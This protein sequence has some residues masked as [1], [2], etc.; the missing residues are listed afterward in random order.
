MKAKTRSRVRQAVLAFPN[1]HGGARKGAG[2]KPT[3]ERAGVAHRTRPEL[4]ER[5]PVH[6]TLRLR[7]GL[8][9][10][11]RR[12]TLA[13][14][15]RC[16]AA[17]GDKP[18]FRLCEFSIQS[19]HLHLIV[20]ASG[21]SALSRGMQGLA[22]RIARALNSAWRRKGTVF[23]DRYHARILE[24]PTEVRN[25]LRYVLHNARHHGTRYRGLDRFSSGPWFTGWLDQTPL[26]SPSP[27]ARA[28]TWLLRTG[29]WQRMRGLSIHC[30]PA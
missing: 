5:F 11:R 6:V 17:G 23:A 27:L 21:K 25:A 28:R 15:H 29:W 22:V 20:E 1:T 4:K 19:N 12:R 3:G 13:V 24:T 30:T 16:F 8:P 7:R 26:E 9:S 18:T 14:L 10:L 2:R